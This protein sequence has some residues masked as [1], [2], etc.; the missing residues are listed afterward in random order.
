ML[1]LFFIVHLFSEL[2]TI[3]EKLEKEK[4]NLENALADARRQIAELKANVDKL[5]QVRVPLLKNK[6]QRS[7]G[8]LDKLSNSYF[9][10]NDTSQRTRFF[11]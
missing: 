8:P 3:I 7:R 5:I 1:K 9:L 4:I 6:I 2:E 10:I 11:H